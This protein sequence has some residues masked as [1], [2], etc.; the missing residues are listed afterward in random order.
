MQ[1][2]RPVAFVAVTDR[3]QARDF[4]QGTLGLDLVADEPFAL[5]FDL[6][7]VPL[8]L[9][10]VDRLEPQP[11]TVLGWQV[12]DIDATVRRLTSAGVV[13]EEYESLDQDPQGTWRSPFGARIAWF[14]DPDGNVLSVTQV[15]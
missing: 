11:F 3:L 7:G 1:A 12:D 9:A 10:L 8:R 4:Y 5:V 13:F 15:S 6:G 2:A 14:K